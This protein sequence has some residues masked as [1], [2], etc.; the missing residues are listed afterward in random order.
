M[1]NDMP[2]TE[3]LTS[4]E[5][6][7]IHFCAY[8]QR[9]SFM[10]VASNGIKS[11]VPLNSNASRSRTP[12]REIALRAYGL[13]PILQVAWSFPLTHLTVHRKTLRGCVRDDPAARHHHGWEALPAWWV[14]LNASLIDTN[15]I[16][17]SVR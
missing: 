3:R 10:P 15:S 6:Y 4:D 12:D 11:L 8:G 13:C 2:E 7:C 5:M 17:R 16:E 14:A 1:Q 9:A